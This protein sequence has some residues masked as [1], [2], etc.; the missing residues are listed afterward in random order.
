MTTRPS[1]RSIGTGR[2]R[3]KVGRERV[4]E[5]EREVRLGKERERGGV[6][7]PWQK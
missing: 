3:R 5:K 6:I 4:G 7:Y 1:R 2:G